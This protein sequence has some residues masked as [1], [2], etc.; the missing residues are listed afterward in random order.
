M[1]LVKSASGVERRHSKF[2]CEAV[3]EFKLNHCCF[4][5]CYLRNVNVFSL[6][7]PIFTACAA[8]QAILLLRSL[9]KIKVKKIEHKVPSDQGIE[10]QISTRIITDVSYAHS[11]TLTAIMQASSWY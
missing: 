11:G 10:L 6:L 1:D 3:W 9:L 2:K 5:K 7:V 8:F 4:W